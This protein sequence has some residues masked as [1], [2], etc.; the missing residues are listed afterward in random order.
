MKLR[1]TFTISAF[2]LLPFVPQE[3]T[4]NGLFEHLNEIPD[5]LVPIDL[6][7]SMLTGSVH[8][9]ITGHH[10]G[11]SVNFLEEPALSSIHPVPKKLCP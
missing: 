11:A 10:I 2:P 7:G 1:T 4:S 9:S 6:I 3:P 5:Q 8:E